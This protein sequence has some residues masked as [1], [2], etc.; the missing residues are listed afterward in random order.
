MYQSIP[1]L[2]LHGKNLYQSRVAVDAALRRMPA[3]VYRLRIIHGSNSG[4]AICEFIREHYA[5]HPRVKRIETGLNRG[6]TEL[7]LRE[8]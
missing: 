7:V 2:D 3:G 8:F 5:A 4:T 1:T 6:M